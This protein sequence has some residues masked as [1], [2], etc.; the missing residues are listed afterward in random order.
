MP[1]Q[2]R[3]AAKP[4]VRL[5]RLQSPPTSLT[6]CSP[7]SFLAPTLD[8]DDHHKHSLT[9][10][11]PPLAG[12]VAAS[13]AVRAIVGSALAPGASAAVAAADPDEAKRAALAKEVAAAAARPGA[14]RPA[15][16]GLSGSPRPAFSAALLATRASVSVTRAIQAAEFGN[17][18]GA[19]VEL[20]RAL[21]T[22]AAARGRVPLPSGA[23]PGDTARLYCLFLQNT[24]LPV[25]FG[26]LLALR[27]LLHIPA[28]QAD[29]LEAEVLSSGADFSI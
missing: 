20:D 14:P 8:P 9:A 7:R 5:L 29:A 23:G 13:L 26:S 6:F 28:D 27:D 22:H 4:G 12:L 24:E 21:R 18:A 15:S 11:A 1:W 16:T 2:G 3:A 19:M 25:D 17:T 10:L